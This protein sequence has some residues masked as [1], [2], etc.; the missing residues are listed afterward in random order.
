MYVLRY[1]AGLMTWITIIAYFVL[2]IAL[3]WLVLNKSKEFTE[4]AEKL[5]PG[6]TTRQSKEND[7]RNL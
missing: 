3:A 1:T 6:T 5:A 2:L 7:A 4:Q